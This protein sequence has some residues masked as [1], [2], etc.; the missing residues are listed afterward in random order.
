MANCALVKPDLVVVATIIALISPEVDLI[1]VVLNELE[2]EGLVPA[3][4]EDIER[5]LAS[6]G[7]SKVE[8]GKLRLKCSDHGLADEGSLIVILK[9]ISLSLGAVS[10]D[11]ANI[12]HT[13]TE[14]NESSSL[15]GDI[16]VGDVVK[17]EVNQSLKGGLTDMATETLSSEVFTSLV[18]IETVLCESVL[19]THGELRRKLLTDLDDVTA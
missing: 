4:R 19:G 8:V 15:D 3:L 16:K 5:D 13:I 6:N 17:D 18:G 9:L 1:V 11:R 14:L 12:D 10:A 7:E 2:A